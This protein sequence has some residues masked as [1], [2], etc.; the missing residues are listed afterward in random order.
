MFDLMVMAVKQ[1]LLS[2]KSPREVLLVTLNHIDA[3]REYATLPQAAALVEAAL[4]LFRQVSERKEWKGKR[5]RKERK[6]QG[7]E[8]RGKS[9]RE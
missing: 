2:C 1:Q 8:R 9:K 6:R 4:A 7:R 3:L 5:E